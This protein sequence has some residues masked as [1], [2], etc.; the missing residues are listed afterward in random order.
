LKPEYIWQVLLVIIG[1]FASAYAGYWVG[2]QPEDSHVIVYREDSIDNLHRIL[3]IADKL[4]ITYEGIAL[5]ELSSVNY[6]I[7]NTSKRNL[8]NVRLYF[9]VEDTMS[10]SIFHLV[11]PP[12]EY[13]ME[14]VSLVSDKDGVYVFDLE[15][16]NRSE[17]LR[18]GFSFAFYFAGGEP[19][20][21]A[22]K[23]GTRGVLL[24]RY[25]P[26]QPSGTEVVLV[27]LEKTW[28]VLLIYG[29]AVYLSIRLSG[30]LRKVKVADLRSTIKAELSGIDEPERSRKVDRIME[31]SMRNPSLR[32]MGLIIFK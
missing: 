22:V 5:S 9:E 32:E 30:R 14:A 29:F 27:V 11:H 24:S 18:D 28:Y 8:D 31:A 4:Q 23:V 1:A 26:K 17:H 20:K 7:A 15:Y 25:V 3:G 10:T 21:M 13:P 16:L 6:Q 19:P 2:K 12:E